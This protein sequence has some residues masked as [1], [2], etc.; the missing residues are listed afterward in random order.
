MKRA[1]VVY[2]SITGNTEKVAN[3]IHQGLIS[4]GMESK[5]CT[6]QEA[7]DEDFYA[8]DLI[9]FG[10]PAYN[11]NLPQVAN[12]YLKKQFRRYKREGRILPGAP[13]LPGKSAL[14]FCTY[15]GPHTGIR[16]AVPAG[17][18]MGQ[19]FE[20]FGFL[21]LDEWYILSEFVGS[22]E[23]STKGRM[24]NIVGLPDERELSRIED[25]ARI[26]VAR[27]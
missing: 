24:G 13:T 6:V 22:E 8:Y 23:Y 4:G 20:H 16:E 17:L 21:V 26:L 15:S 3:S 10:A 11:W 5:I 27:I 12:D 2:Q 1:L 14:I 7:A 19:F 25:S 9:C 18:Y